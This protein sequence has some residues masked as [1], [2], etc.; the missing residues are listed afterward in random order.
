VPAGSFYAVFPHGLMVGLFGPVFGLAALALAMG[1]RRFWRGLPDEP[2]DDGASQ[3][4]TSAPGL[5]L[6]EAAHDALTLK[7]LDGGHGQG[8]NNADDAFTHARRRCHHLTFY[9][10]VLCFAATSVATLYHYAFGWAAPYGWASLPKLLG[11]SGGL[12][13]ATG[14]A[15]LA[16]LHARRHVLQRAPEQA[17]MDLGF[18]AL[19]FL[20]AVTGLAL[21]ALRGTAAMPLL[22]CLHLGVVMALFLTL[23]YGKFA[24][25]LYRGAALLKWAIEKRRPARLGLGGD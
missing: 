18:I 13:L 21:A 8:C 25:G 6:A 20:C 14:S 15:G 16:W 19:L 3:A 2:P 11:V 4:G 23:P 17:G 7:Y 22:L 12:M 5:A 24:H 10:F 1:L 9:G